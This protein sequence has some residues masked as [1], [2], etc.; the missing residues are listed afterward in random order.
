MSQPALK[1][2]E[3]SVQPWWHDFFD[4]AYAAYGLVS[5]D[6]VEDAQRVEFLVRTLEL[7]P[8]DR[9]FD[10]CCGIGRLSLPLA[11]RGMRIVGVDRVASYI[12][13][14]RRESARRGLKDCEF[15]CGDAAEF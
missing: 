4:D 5:I 7:E 15:H 13:A 6:P 11:E 12:E 2:T 9:I 3:E 10:Q 8:G 14:A 1:R